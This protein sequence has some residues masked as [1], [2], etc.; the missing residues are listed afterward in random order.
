MNEDKLPGLPPCTAS[1]LRNRVYDTPPYHK[2]DISSTNRVNEEK[3]E[4]CLLL[5][6]AIK[7]R[8]KY[9][10]D[11]QK[12]KDFEEQQAFKQEVNRTPLK[13]IKP[14][15]NL[16]VSDPEVVWDKD[17]GLISVPS[18][19]VFSS[20]TYREF[21]EDSEWFYNSCIQSKAN[22]TFCYQ[23]LSLLEK[24]YELHILLNERYEDDLQT[25]NKVDFHS[26]MKVDNHLHAAGS[27]T[28]MEFLQFLKKKMIDEPD[29]VIDK[30]GKKLSDCLLDCGIVQPEMLTTDALQMK[31]KKSTFHRFDHFNDSY[32]PMGRADLRTIF[33]KTSNFIEGRFFS[34][35][36]RDTVIAR[37]SSK[38]S[39]RQAL[40]PRLSIYAKPDNVKWLVQIPRL[41]N[42]FMGKVYNN[43]GELMQNIFDPILQATLHPEKHPEL[44]ILLDEFT[45]KGTGENSG[46]DWTERKNPPY[47]YWMFF[48]S[49]NLK[50]VNIIREKRGMNIFKFAPH[51]GESGP[52]HHLA[53]AFLTADHVQHGVNVAKLPVAMYLFYLT[54]FPMGVCPMSND[55]LFLKLE[56]SP[57]RKFVKVGMNF[58]LNTDDPLQFHTTNDPLLEEYL[59]SAASFKLSTHDMS[60]IAFNSVCMSHFDYAT[61]TQWVGEGFDE[62]HTESDWFSNPDA[63]NVCS[64]RSDYRHR[65]LIAEVGYVYEHAKRGNN[66]KGS[67]QDPGYWE[68]YFSSTSPIVI[69]NCRWLPR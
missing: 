62:P 12:E 10:H 38:H 57:V 54:Q 37:C 18:L 35:L 64:I 9:L 15:L 41:C 43:F 27:M 31:A 29:L 52:R 65:A 50:L 49:E 7:L 67:T 23:R 28:E 17:T 48:L 59:V 4:S 34:E 51:C 42:I 46:F 44:H 2:I 53:S 26:V 21:K 58:S 63:T 16:T 68:D 11:F 24:Q 25:E 33:M 40:E 32:N 66:F 19:D 60:E 14:T 36:V 39:T 3:F 1:H 47:N 55:K 5:L 22:N 8:Q 13:F 30:E 56:D 6:R 20:R 45:L 69:G 61:K